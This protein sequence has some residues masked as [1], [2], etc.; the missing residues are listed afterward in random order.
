[1]R[2]K[3]AA[4]TLGSQLQSI[5][6]THPIHIH[7]YIYIYIYIYTYIFIQILI[8]LLTISLFVDIFMCLFIIESYI[9]YIEYLISLS[10]RYDKRTIINIEDHRSILVKIYQSSVICDI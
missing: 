8:Y 10:S 2:M 1:M 7:I 3:P 4:C 9:I 6:H 5:V